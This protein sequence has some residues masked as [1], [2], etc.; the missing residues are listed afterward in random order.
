[1]NGFE[2][3]LIRILFFF[4]MANMWQKQKSLSQ[5]TIGREDRKA[6]NLTEEIQLSFDEHRRGKVKPYRCGNASR[7]WIA[8][9]NCAAKSYPYSE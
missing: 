8:H 4:N 9:K 3:S 5:Y 6:V 7:I 1:M 2:R